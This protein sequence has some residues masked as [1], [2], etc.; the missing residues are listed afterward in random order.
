[1]SSMIF[2]RMVNSVVK[3]ASIRVNLRVKTGGETGSSNGSTRACM[4]GRLY[5]LKGPYLR[6]WPEVLVVG[7]KSR[8]RGLA[9]Y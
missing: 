6:G 2:R 1:M 3:N 5:F 9:T 8:K 7:S 4:G